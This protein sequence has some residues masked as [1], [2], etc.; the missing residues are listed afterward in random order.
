MSTKPKIDS[1]TAPKPGYLTTEFLLA[2]LVLIISGAMVIV[3][4]NLAASQWIN[5]A[6]WLVP[7]YGLSRGLAKLST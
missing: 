1:S 7:G 5:L 4:K 2:A 6:K 3:S